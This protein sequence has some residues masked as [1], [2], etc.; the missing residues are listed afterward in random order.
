MTRID[1]LLQRANLLITYRQF[2][3][4]AFIFWGILAIISYIQSTLVWLLS[5]AQTMYVSESI[6]WL[7]NY[8]LWLGSSP[9]I[10]YAAYRFPFRLTGSNYS[11]PR[12]IIIHVLIA[13]A[14]GLLITVISYALVRPLHAH[15]TGHWM[16]PKTILLWF[17]YGYS[18]SV[19]TY[20]LV[21]VG[22]SIISYT[23]HYQAL[24]EQNLKYELNNEQLKTQLT[25]AQL[26]SL[27]MQLNPHF[28]FNT[29]H[30]IVSLMLQNDTRKA[31]DM[32]TAL[33][34]LLRGVLAHQTENFLT[35]RDELN[36]TQQYL[37]IQQ[38]RFQDRLRIEYDIDPATEHCLVPQ[39][40]LQPLVENAIT[41]GI[42][43][44]TNDALIRI[45]TRKQEDSIQLTVFDNGVG[46]SSS[47]TYRSGRNGSGL[48]LNNT[49]LRLAQAFGKA[50]QFTFD[51]PSGGNT[52]VIIT[53]PYQP[54]LLTNST[55]DNLSFA[56]Y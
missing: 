55:H 32:V 20:L 19:I 2:W 33:S 41:H 8:L 13:S 35:L 11:W 28:L 4:Y 5:N 25:S 38:I 52:R 9:L 7:I 34:D 46:K 47:D 30:A 27:K 6:Q 23:T 22:Y 42:S 43:S 56:H 39:L 53:F 29:H 49:R 45:T 44:L 16:N 51:Q 40:I 50:A 24:K 18:L 15:E 54:S 26:Q 36:L 12:T 48:G 17:F 10:L 1:K 37:A 21:V 14:L 3:R 31:I